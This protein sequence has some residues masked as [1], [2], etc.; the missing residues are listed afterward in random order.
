MV[1]ARAMEK[2]IPVAEFADIGFAV[3]RS[4]HFA[5]AAFY[6]QKAI[7]K[8]FIGIAASNAP[9]HMAPF[10]GRARFLGTNPIA[11][12]LPA[13]QEPPLLFDASTSVVARGK[14]IVAAQ[15]GQGDSRG[16]GH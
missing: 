3:R 11:V 2:A 9:P 1:G 12:G 6:G 7:H 15:P 14:I 4:N 5:I 16:L 8:G 10:G 13:G